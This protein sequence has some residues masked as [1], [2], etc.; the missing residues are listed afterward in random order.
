VRALETL[1][2]GQTDA[3]VLAGDELSDAGEHAERLLAT[4]VRAVRPGGSVFVSALG[5]VR[6]GQEE[7]GRPSTGR[8]FLSEQLRAALGHA[9]LAV[10]FMAAP[11][12]A[13]IVSG[14]G[15]AAY[16]PRDRLPGLLDA[17]PRVVALG[18]APRSPDERSA[19][20]FASLPLKV[21]AAAT[22]CRDSRGRL[23]V[24][25]DSFR[26]LWTIPG[27]VVDRDEDPRSGAVRETWEEA[28][29]RVDVGALL[30]VFSDVWPDRIALL[31][32]AMPIAPQGSPA[33]VHTHEIGEAA[34]LDLDAALARLAPYV[35]A[36]VTHCLEHPGGTW[37]RG[38]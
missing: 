33:P 17:A 3:L 13:A 1:P 14:A 37:A 9:G 5:A 26:R 7:V 31:Y 34:W 11:G 18:R 23:L 20:F 36:Q 27:G 10:E 2:A 32:A 16:D 12:A 28:G 19:N 35:R 4:S 6:D 22:V 25:Y 24:V 21:V 29:V 30:G 38:Y 15:P 8:R